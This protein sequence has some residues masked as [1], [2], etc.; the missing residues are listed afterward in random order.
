[1]SNQSRNRIRNGRGGEEEGGGEIIT[2]RNGANWRAVTLAFPR[3][4]PLLPPARA[5]PTFLAAIAR[6]CSAQARLWRN[7]GFERLWGCRRRGG[8]GIASGQPG[9]R[10]DAGVLHIV[11]LVGPKKA[12][13]TRPKAKRLQ[14][15]HA[16]RFSSCI[17][18]RTA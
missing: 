5:E 9:S 6:A 15:L 7:G 16:L 12:N 14:P 13:Q 11:G 3:A 4:P 2:R 8:G 18:Q 17:H 1:V 10:V